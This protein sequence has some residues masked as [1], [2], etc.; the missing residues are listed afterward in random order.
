MRDSNY[1][2]L[3]PTLRYTLRSLVRQFSHEVLRPECLRFLSMTFSIDIKLSGEAVQASQ[4][5]L[6]HDM[7][8]IT[9]GILNMIPIHPDIELHDDEERTAIY[10]QYSDQL[11]RRLHDQG[12]D[13]ALKPGTVSTRELSWEALELL[14]SQIGLAES[15]SRRKAPIF[16]GLIRSGLFDFLL[17][18]AADPRTWV[19]TQADHICIAN[20]LYR[21][22]VRAIRVILSRFEC[23][24]VRLKGAAWKTAVLLMLWMMD[25]LYNPMGPYAG[26]VASPAWQSLHRAVQKSISALRVHPLLAQPDAQMVH[27]SLTFLMNCTTALHMPL[28]MSGQRGSTRYD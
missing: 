9:T 18:L 25:Q 6:G 10:D 16:N 15:T 13:L 8:A 27:F 19:F 2:Y 21:S 4:H 11:I 1:S 24:I 17:E 14:V 26:D 5:T 3:R 28:M 12:L 20:G 7:R 22:L 23:Q